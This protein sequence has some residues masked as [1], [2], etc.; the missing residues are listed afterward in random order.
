MLTAVRAR[1]LRGEIDDISLSKALLIADAVGLDL[2][3]DLVARPAPAGAQDRT[4]R[5]DCRPYGEIDLEYAQLMP[6]AKVRDMLRTMWF[7]FAT[8]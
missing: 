4:C 3:E 8:R 6:G 5:A 2:N 1:I 7:T